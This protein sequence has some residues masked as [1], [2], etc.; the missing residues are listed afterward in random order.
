MLRELENAF[1]N[2]DNESRENANTTVGASLFW[3]YSLNKVFNKE[4]I[5]AEF[6]PYDVVRERSEGYIYIHKLPLS[7]VMP[8]CCGWS[9]KKLLMRGLV[10]PSVSS[11]PAKHLDTAVSHIVNFFFM[12]ANEWTGAQAMSAIDLFLAPF[13]KVDKLTRKQVRQ[14][15]QK[16][17]YE[18]NFSTRIGFQPPY[19]NITVCL[20]QLRNFLEE[21]AVVGGKEVGRID[22][23]MD[24][25]QIIVEELLKLYYEGDSYGKPFTFPILTLPIT[26]RFRWNSEISDMIFRVLAYR[27]SIYILNGYS[28][29]VEGLYAMCC[30]L[31]IDFRK[32]NNNAFGIKVM[33]E[34]DEEIYEYLRK[35]KA[36][37]GIW[38]I[39]DATGSIGVVT[40]NLP[41]LASESKDIDELIDRIREKAEHCRKVLTIW[42]EKYEK[43]LG[44]GFFPLTKIYNPTF[45]SHFS[46][47]GVIGLP[48]MAMI[49]TNS[50]KED[51]KT[52]DTAKGLIRI[53][54]A[55][56]EELTGITEEYE[57]QD[58]VLYNVEEIPGESASY[59]LAE[60]DYAKSEK[61]R[62]LFSQLGI[63]PIYSNS[64]VPYYVDIPLVMR[65]EYE[66]EVQPLFTGGVML[67]IFIGQAVDHRSLRRFIERIVKN[68]KLVYF[69]ITPSLTYCY[70]CRSTVVGAMRVCPVCGSEKTEIWSR[71]V[72]YY[73]PI[74]SWSK[75]RRKEYFTRVMYHI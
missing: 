54:K 34:E 28:V 52:K 41:K 1:L 38:A 25:A 56:I 23:Y 5:L 37:R 36:G 30:R 31:T 20:D 60:K 29:D 19:T 40:I 27:G 70:A 8:Y 73:R 53:E 45:S 62:R 15:L 66:S 72:G 26:P 75:Q 57:K 51:W 7:L 35:H 24:E 11:K 55:V 46:T 12:T 3:M 63:S 42:R 49:L 10:T 33:K 61:I 67:H 9:I 43:L 32:L 17:V 64:V 68:T 74:S 50:T 2:G 14:S 48:E 6:F 4:E 39:P 65:I 47:I 18:L 69:S 13:I 71:I 58:G 21:E 22:E 16:L 59:R 44:S